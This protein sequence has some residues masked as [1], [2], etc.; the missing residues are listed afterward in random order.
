MKSGYFVL[1]NEL[2]QSQQWTDIIWP[3]MCKS[4]FIVETKPALNG[5]T[6]LHGVSERFDDLPEG[7][8][9]QYEATF[10]GNKLSEIRSV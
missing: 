6:E 10:K 3:E 9:K 1:T 7:S 2:L 4:F 8:S 5:C